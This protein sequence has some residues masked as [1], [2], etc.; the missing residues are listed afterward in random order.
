MK[1]ARPLLPLLA[2]A[3]LAA[4]APAPPEAPPAAGWEELRALPP[5]Q[6]W[7]EAGRHAPERRAGL[8]LDLL[9]DWARSGRWDALAARLPELDALDLGPPAADRRQRLRARLLLHRG[10]AAAA[11]AALAG[12]PDGDEVLALRID[13][14]ERLG[15]VQG[16]LRARLA[17]AAPAS[18]A[19]EA[20]W[21]RLLATP[22]AQLQAWRDAAADPA[23]RGWLDLALLSRPGSR[24]RIS[25]EETLREWELSYGGGHPARARLPAAL[26]TLRALHPRVRRLAA[27]LP[28]SGDYAPIG[29]ALRAGIEARM[30][31]Q[32][33]DEVP[34]LRIYDTGDPARDVGELYRQAVAEGAERIVGP[35]RKEAV[36]RLARADA[37]FAPTVSLNYLPAAAGA[38]AALVQFGLL[39][40]DE[41]LQAAERALADGRRAAAVFAP[42]D[43]WGRRLADAFA[44]RFEAGGGAVRSRAFYFPGASDYAATI[45][46]A[47]R[48]SAGERRRQA[49]EEALGREVVA[50]PTRRRDLD[51]VFLAGA[52]RS[53]RLFKP[54]LDF[55]RAAD[56]PVYAT[57]HVYAGVP[58]PLQD[59]DLDGIRFCDLPLVLDERLAA[60]RDA[61]P[62]A[63]Q[64]PRFAALGADAYLLAMNLDYL[65]LRPRA[66]LEGWTGTLSLRE[67]R[68]VFRALL[69]WA[70]FRRGRAVPLAAAAAR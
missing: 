7:A 20:A 35:F 27:L 6:A 32:P 69:P 13:A 1:A 29:Q 44:A 43:D 39:P 64:L 19:G 34:E 40:E 60:A 63:R 17:R 65:R 12:L 15:D 41:A 42:A 50:P 23:W 51:M 9:E 18:A 3:L 61:G 5:D 62:R 21:E 26:Q 68:R 25:P 58:S 10:E 38:P 8:R 14:R 37:A 67:G 28:V 59:Q 2:A 49:V 66:R 52:P 22:A 57:S 47:L 48:L 11:L 33:P 4:C 70:Q 46:D 24:P 31:A 36:A 53:A 30:R 16:A 54:Q 45:K 56:L 55:Y